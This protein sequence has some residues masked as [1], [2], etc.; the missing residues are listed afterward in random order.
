MTQLSPSFRKLLAVAFLLA[1]VSLPLLAAYALVAG[2]LANAAEIAQKRQDLD[3]LEA[4][5]RYAARLDTKAPDEATAAFAGWFLPEADPAIAAA[6]LQARLKAIAQSQ[7]VDVVQASNVKPRT[8]KGI[9][10]V[11]VSLDMMGR[12]EGIHGTL[13]EIER[14]MPLLLIDKL[15]LRADLAGDDPRYDPVR[16]NLAIE[17][18][19]ALLAP[20]SPEAGKAAEAQKTP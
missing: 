3:K 4:I 11:G 10:L 19:A 6:N 1:A 2:Y 14:A 12:A 7:M 18:W 16:L 8:E 13:R 9:G 20:P 15:N 5:A 17:V